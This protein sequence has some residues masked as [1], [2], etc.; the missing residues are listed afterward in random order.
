MPFKIPSHLSDVSKTLAVNFPKIWTNEATIQFAKRNV[1]DLFVFISV[2][3]LFVKHEYII[4]PTMTEIKYFMQKEKD[5]RCFAG[6][7][8]RAD[9]GKKVAP[10]IFIVALARYTMNVLASHTLPIPTTTRK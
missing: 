6:P 1:S 8:S 5:Q 2:C 7:L 9:C 10:E 4:R 3:C